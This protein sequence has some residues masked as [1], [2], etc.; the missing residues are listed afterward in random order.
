M[1]AFC[2]YHR[3]FNMD[4]ENKYPTLVWICFILASTITSNEYHNFYE[5]YKSMYPYMV[6]TLVPAIYDTF[7]QFV[8]A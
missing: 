8:E 3:K 5:K 6:Y 4:N 2:K 7:G 1:I